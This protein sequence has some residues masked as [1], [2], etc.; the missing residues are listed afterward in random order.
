MPVLPQQFFDTV[1]Y[2][3][4][5]ADSADKGERAGGSGCVVVIPTQTEP[6]IAGFMYV[7][8]SSHVIREGKAS[9][10]R[11]NTRDG[12]VGIIYNTST[13]W[14]HHPDGDDIA[15]L[16]VSF[17]YEKIKARGIPEE[18]FITREKLEQYRIGPGD[19]AFIVGRFVNHE[20]KQQNLPAVRFGQLSMLPIEPIRTPRGLLQEAFLVECRSLPGYSGSPVF[21]APMP[22]NTMVRKEVPPAMFLGIDMGHLT[23]MQP[24]LKKDELLQNGKRVPV[25]GNWTV[26]TNTGMSCVVPAWKVRELLY[27]EELVESRKEVL[28]KFETQKVSSAVAFDMAEPEK[29]TFTKDDFEAALKKASRKITP[30]S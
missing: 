1:V 13:G 8:T 3:Y 2:L 11:T 27:V 20:G 7:I 23:D 25:D 4:P 17:D 5:D 24:V 16:P 10:L 9:A 22:F 6:F 21:I 30:K 14:I 26:E 29:T 15:A 28:K 12:G 19:E 18:W